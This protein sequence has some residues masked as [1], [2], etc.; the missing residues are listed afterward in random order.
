ML[1]VQNS[2]RFPVGI[3]YGTGTVSVILT[4]DTLSL[5]NVTITDQG[6]GVATSLSYEFASTS[7]DGLVVRHSDPLSYQSHMQL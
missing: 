3:Q 4:Y 2:S 6:F 7:C 1:P 5:A